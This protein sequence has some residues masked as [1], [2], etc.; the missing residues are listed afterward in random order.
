MPTVPTPD[1]FSEPVVVYS[2]A[3]CPYCI[4]AY[5]LLERG[6]YPFARVDVSGDHAAREWLVQTT[7]RTTVPQIFIHGEN[8]GGYDE[9]SALE[10]KGELQTRIR[11]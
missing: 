1:Q 10:R 4:M 6:K 8:I 7:S 3:Y 11:G 9:L 2:T 5:R